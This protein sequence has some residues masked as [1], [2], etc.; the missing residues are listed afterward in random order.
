MTRCAMQRQLLRTGLV[1]GGGGG[2]GGGAVRTHASLADTER[3]AGNSY[4]PRLM[5]LDSARRRGLPWAQ[6]VAPGR[7]LRRQVHIAGGGRGASVWESDVESA[8]QGRGQCVHMPRIRMHGAAQ[9]PT[10]VLE[11]A[12]AVLQGP[13]PVSAARPAGLPSAQR[14]RPVKACSAVRRVAERAVWRHLGWAGAH[15][16]ARVVV[17]AFCGL[18]SSRQG[19]R[20]GGAAEGRAVRA[21]QASGARWVPVA[22]RYPG[23]RGRGAGGGVFV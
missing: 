10:L 14:S 9:V 7:L 5:A 4:A 3:P 18:A 13:Q 23:P 15:R 22:H 17:P 2:G 16:S 12:E 19:Q 11:G 6:S 1:T 20:R 8:C 21:I